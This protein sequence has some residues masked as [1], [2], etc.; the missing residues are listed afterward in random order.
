MQNEDGYTLLAF[1]THYGYVNI[2]D[3]L[4]RAGANPN[5]PNSEQKGSNTPLHIAANYGFKKIQDLLIENQAD[6]TKRNKFGMTPW[7]GFVPSDDEHA[8]Q[9]YVLAKEKFAGV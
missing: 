7:E 4:L 2:V 9:D 8:M 1:A 5:I 3:I 6:E